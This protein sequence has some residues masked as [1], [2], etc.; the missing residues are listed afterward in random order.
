MESTKLFDDLTWDNVV[1]KQD[2]LQPIWE[3]AVQDLK[4]RDLQAV[5]SH[6]KIKGVN[7]TSK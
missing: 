3:F 6:L 2:E 4:H 7:N 5:C 1:I